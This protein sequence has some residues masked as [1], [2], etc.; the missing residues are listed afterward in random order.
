MTDMDPLSD[1][2]QLL[3]ARSYVTSGQSAGGQWSMRYPGFDGMKFIALRKGHVWFRLDSSEEWHSL[4][5]GD[6]VLLTRSAP[7]ILA[8]DKTLKP[9]VSTGVPY[10]MR[11]GL[12]DYGGD[13]SVLLAGKME[14]DPI[15][16]GQLL[17][18]L[19]TVIHFKS[20]SEV[21]S[22]MNWLMNRLHQE[23]RSSRPGA[24]LAS[25]HLMELMMIE[26]IRNW[27]LSDDAELSGWMGGT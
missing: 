12:A 16:A 15:A 27:I 26:G 10:Q 7:F 19:P 5:P 13:D 4:L 21:S 11:D 23:N 3:A 8:A 9:L 17:D 18:V 2:L 24:S 20:G 22:A 14:I 25:N 6:G 1:V